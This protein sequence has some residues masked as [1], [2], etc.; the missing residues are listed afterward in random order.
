VK[1]SSSFLILPLIFGASLFIV[2]CGGGSVQPAASTP[3]PPSTPGG[4]GG[5]PTPLSFGN[6]QVANGGASEACPAGLNFAPGVTCYRATVS[7]PNA[8]DLGLTFGYQAPSGTPRGTIVLYSGGG[9]TESGSLSDY[10]IYTADYVNA[11]FA[12]IETA[13]D[14][15][16]GWEDTTNGIAGGSVAHSILAAG[17]RPATF[18]NY[19]FNTPNPFYASGGG[20]CAQGI[21]GG[22]GAVAYSLSA[23]AADAFLDNV[24]LQ[25]GPVF[26]DIEQGCEVPAAPDVTV[27]GGNDTWCHLGSL[28]SWTGPPSYSGTALTAVQGFVGDS[29]CGGPSPT[30][31]ASNST[32]KAMSIVNGTSNQNFTYAI[33]VTAWLCAD[34]SNNSTEQGELFY[35][36]VGATSTSLNVYAVQGCQ[37]AEGV[38][39][40]T[41]PALANANGLTATETDMINAC[42]KIH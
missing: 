41:V 35:Q 38:D 7:C 1:R 20:R 18:L 11:G 40:G 9:G 29:S 25:S 16:P 13:W 4:G 15:P 21:S 39:H 8:M 37:G 12:V 24:E 14:G 17:C 33:P 3:A 34:S 19:V 6:V 22:S 32:W 30:S 27:C 2:S 5:T 36:Q 42:H 23:Y 10:G 31:S 28:S 26:S